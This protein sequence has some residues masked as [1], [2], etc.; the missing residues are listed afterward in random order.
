MEMAGIVNPSEGT[1]AM[2]IDAALLELLQ[3]EKMEVAGPLEGAPTK[4]VEVESQ[5]VQAAMEVMEP[6]GVFHRQ[7]PPSALHN[8]L[9]PALCWRTSKLLTSHLG[10]FSH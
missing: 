6:M 2:V 4:L 7:P 8:L 1:P 10:C 3:M 9:L 5:R